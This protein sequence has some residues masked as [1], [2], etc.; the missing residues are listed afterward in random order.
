MLIVLLLP[1]SGYGALPGF[2]L[3]RMGTLS[4]QVFVNGE[5]VTNAIASFFL[6][7]EGLPPVQRGMRRIP[8]FLTRLDNEGRFSLKLSAGKYYMG[9][10]L[11]EPAKGVGPPR[12]GEKYYFAVDA[13]GGLRLLEIADRKKIDVG[14]V[15]GASPES[16]SGLVDGSLSEFITVE[17]V[18]LDEHGAPYPGAF[19]LGKKDMRTPRPEFISERTGDDGRFSLKL[20]AGKTFF[21]IARENI[22]ATRPRPGQRI[23]TYGILS[24]TGLA[25]PVIFG[26]GGPPPGVLDKDKSSGDRAL[27]VSGA[28]GDTVTG[29]TIHMYKVPDPREIKSSLKGTPDSPKFETGALMNNVS[30]KDNGYH[31]DPKSFAE[32]DRWA[33]FLMGTKTIGFEISVSADNTGTEEFN[34]ILAELRADAVSQYLVGRGVS[35]ECIIVKEYGGERSVS[36]N[37]TEEGM[38][39]NPRVKIRFIRK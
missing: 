33:A 1:A 21:L 28:K 6:E 31:L 5:P 38:N 14:R 12:Q 29:I 10:L 22:S 2:M 15:D 23:G 32:L 19:V 25:S 11:R 39:G 18:V 24:K 7:S 36:D 16:F 27:I 4:G 8:E 30:F 34:R 9:I 26:I 17:G 35:P 20:P 3:K 13:A 37:K